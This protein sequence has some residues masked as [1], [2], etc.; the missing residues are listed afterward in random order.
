M[1]NL[2]AVMNIMAQNEHQDIHLITE[3]Q[4]EEEDVRYAKMLSEPFTTGGAEFIG[5]DAEAQICINNY[6][7]KTPRHWE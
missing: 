7:A 1:D 5:N 2:Y 4:I 6:L 3:E